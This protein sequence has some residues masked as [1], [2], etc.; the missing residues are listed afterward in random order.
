MTATIST[1]ELVEVVG[2]GKLHVESNR[3]LHNDFSLVCTVWCS[4]FLDPC[5]HNCISSNIWMRGV[6]L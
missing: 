2:V 5:I 3:D 1:V 4:E 6:R